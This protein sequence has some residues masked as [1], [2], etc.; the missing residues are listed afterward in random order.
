MRFLR[1]EDVAEEL[2]V[3]LPQIRALIKSGE[4]PAIQIGGRGV[5]RVEREKLE[6][7]IQ[8]RYAQAREEIDRES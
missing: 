1:L 8:T 4:L 7:Y 5:W 6:E 2:N 3:K